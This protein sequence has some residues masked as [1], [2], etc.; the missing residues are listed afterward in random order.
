[1]GVCGERVGLPFFYLRDVDA[2]ERLILDCYRMAKY[3]GRNPREF[4]AM[5]V[6][7]IMR[8]VAWTIKLEQTLRPD[9]D[10]E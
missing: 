5:P 3:Y 1:M 6:Y 4:L 10:G 2:V 8:H 9:D 7:E